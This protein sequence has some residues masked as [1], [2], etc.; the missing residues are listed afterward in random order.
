MLSV[1]ALFCF[2]AG[3]TE[4]TKRKGIAAFQESFVHSGQPVVSKGRFTHMILLSEQVSRNCDL[5][6]V[7]AIRELIKNEGDETGEDNTLEAAVQLTSTAPTQPT[8]NSPPGH[9]KRQFVILDLAGQQHF[10]VGHRPLMLRSQPAYG[11]DAS[12]SLHDPK[13]EVF[14]QDQSQMAL[15]GAQTGQETNWMTT[16]FITLLH[17]FLKANDAGDNPPYHNMQNPVPLKWLKLTV[18]KH[19]L[20]DSQARLVAP[21]QEAKTMTILI[22]QRDT[23]HESDSLISLCI[24][25][26]LH[27]TPIEEQQ[28]IGNEVDQRLVKV[29]Y[30]CKLDDHCKDFEKYDLNEKDI[31]LESFEIYI[32]QE[33][34]LEKT[35]YPWPARHWFLMRLYKHCLQV[36]VES[37]GPYKGRH[38][39]FNDCQS[40]LQF[41][42]PDLQF[43]KRSLATK[44]LFGRNVSTRCQRLLNITPESYKQTKGLFIR[45]ECII[46]IP[47]KNPC[48]HNTTSLGMFQDMSTVLGHLLQCKVGIILQCYNIL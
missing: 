32:W 31:F 47:L 10:Y 28:L 2:T 8:N 1:F 41:L 39:K 11:C 7:S 43:A 46:P 30:I 9:E 48:R 23:D 26:V 19:C 3:K 44:V 36:N 22:C 33:N 4:D 12:L 14:G 25:T 45:C 5:A 17:V 18:I 27:S 35:K 37:E 38:K 29:S 42:R 6:L 16:R 20:A 15:M 34:S 24:D 40:L 13:T 21:L